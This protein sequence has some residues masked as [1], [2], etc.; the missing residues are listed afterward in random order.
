MTK[1]KLKQG[2]MN[3][4]TLQKNQNFQT[5]HTSNHLKAIKQPISKRL[6]E[7]GLVKGNNGTRGFCTHKKKKKFLN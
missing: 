1:F 3:Q 2:Q 4:E 6:N 7:I 5:M